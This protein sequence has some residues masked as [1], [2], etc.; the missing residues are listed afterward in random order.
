MKKSPQSSN[1]REDYNLY[2]RQILDVYCRNNCSII[3]DYHSVTDKLGD[4]VFG[5]VH[6]FCEF[7]AF[8][9][10]CVVFDRYD[11]AEFNCSSARY[12]LKIN[13][14]IVLLDFRAVCC[15]T[16]FLR[17]CQRKR[18]GGFLFVNVNCF[19]VL[20]PCYNIITVYHPK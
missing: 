5:G 17:Q 14:H 13:I 19:H 2:Q 7:P 15:L 8:I 12:K 6:E 4:V 9:G 18:R 10:C 11:I 3:G 20:N 1:P 16:D